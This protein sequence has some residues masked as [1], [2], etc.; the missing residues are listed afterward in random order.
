MKQNLQGSGEPLFEV[1]WPLGKT[2]V[3]KS[4]DL[5][6]PITDLN[7]KTVGE[8]WAT[9]YRGDEMF[10]ILR[11]ELKKKFPDV[12][13]V[14]HSVT[15]SIYLGTNER[16]YADVQLPALLRQHG[17]DAVIAAVGA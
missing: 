15:G 13:F 10:R 14:E 4:V 3:A 5:A 7:G 11:E 17:C 6:P 16:E 1:V 9:L 8:M 12:R 2:A